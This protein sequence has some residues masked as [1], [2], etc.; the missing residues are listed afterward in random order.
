[1]QHLLINGQKVGVRQEIDIMGDSGVQKLVQL[2]SGAWCLGLT[3][4]PTYVKSMDQ[5][6]KFEGLPDSIKQ[7]V[8][9]WLHKT[10][11]EAKNPKPA[12]KIEPNSLNPT[13]IEMMAKA[14]GSM[15]PETQAALLQVV[16]SHLD[17][18]RESQTQGP[19]VNSIEGYGQDQD[20]PEFQDGQLKQEPGFYTEFKHPEGKADMDNP[21]DFDDPNVVRAYLK[22]KGSNELDQEAF[23]VER[24][25]RDALEE[26]IG[27]LSR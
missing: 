22:E 10:E 12:P 2:I 18:V 25:G 6:D 27:N 13:P 23:L 8:E 15:S 17:Q 7:Q 24:E 19:E 16:T 11:E 5:L 26:E 21:L 1:M 14:M 20:V 4:P 9:K 3:L